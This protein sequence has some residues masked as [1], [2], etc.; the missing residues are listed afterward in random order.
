MPQTTFSRHRTLV[1][2]GRRR[3]SNRSKA[4]ISDRRRLVGDGPGRR[5]KYSN[6]REG[7]GTTPRMKKAHDSSEDHQGF[8]Y[9]YVPMSNKRSKDVSKQ[10]ITEDKDDASSTMSFFS[11]LQDEIIDDSVSPDSNIHRYPKSITKSKS[12]KFSSSSLES[13]LASLLIET[14]QANQQESGCSSIQ[15]DSSDGITIYSENMASP[16]LAATSVSHTPTSVLTPSHSF[17]QENDPYAQHLCKNTYSVPITAPFQ[18]RD[19]SLQRIPSGSSMSSTNWGQFVDVASAEHELVK[20][21]QILRRRK[22]SGM[23][24]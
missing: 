13:A 19:R 7:L 1:Y 18:G 12:T 4:G 10:S 22:Y 8:L 21:S 11:A 15:Q 24:I 17:N 23:K 16:S 2:N 20:Y 5:Q 9:F 6:E 3:N 14:S